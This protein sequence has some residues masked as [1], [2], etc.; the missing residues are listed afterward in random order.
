MQIFRLFQTGFGLCVI[1]VVGIV[2][3]FFAIA[4]KKDA[5]RM[6]ERKEGLFLVDPNL[7]AFACLLGGIT[8]VVA[9]WAIHYS[10]LRPKRENMK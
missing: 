6:I 4:V 1:L 3:I 5:E 10:T 2:H 8:T 9:Y 7:W